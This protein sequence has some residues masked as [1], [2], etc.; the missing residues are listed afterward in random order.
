MSQR[1]RSGG[2]PFGP[3]PSMNDTMRF[4]MALQ[5]PPGSNP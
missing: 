3:S 1:T 4:H 2:V 5:S